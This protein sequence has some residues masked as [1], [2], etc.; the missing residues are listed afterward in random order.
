MASDIEIKVLQMLQDKLDEDAADSNLD[1]G[2]GELFVSTQ[3]EEGGP[4]IEFVVRVE[5]L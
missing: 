4:Y 2:E 5:V 3:I 1:E